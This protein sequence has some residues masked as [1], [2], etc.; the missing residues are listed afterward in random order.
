MEDKYPLIDSNFQDFCGSCGIFT[1]EDFLIHDLN[2]LI[3]FAGKQPNSERLKQ[4]IDQV[5]SIVDGLHRPWLNGVELLKDAQEHKQTLSLAYEGIDPLLN[6]ALREGFVTELVCLQ[7]T[8]S[9]AKGYAGHIVFIDSGNSFSAPRIAQILNQISHASSIQD[10]NEALHILM[11]NI[12]CYPVFDIF[13]LFD[14]LHQ[15][16]L[17]LKSQMCSVRL[18]IVDSFSSL[19]IPILGGNGP[20]G[21]ALMISAGNLL[22]KIA[23]E[24]SISVLVTNHMVAGENGSTKP[25][26]GESWKSCWESNKVQ[27]L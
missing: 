5:L 20:Y 2:A 10:N 19:I 25:A 1:V 18:L 27:D 11:E 26:L 6:G 8:A 16:E 3:P 7:A 9:V 21:H 4:G 23:H 24:Y 14:V 17:K 22:K 13:S 12:W 15:L